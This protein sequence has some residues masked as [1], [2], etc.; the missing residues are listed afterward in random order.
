MSH[1]A[2]PLT[3][4]SSIGFGSSLKSLQA[5]VLRGYATFTVWQHHRKLLRDLESMPIAMRK[6]LGWPAIDTRQR[7]QNTRG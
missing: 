5:T 2:H 1:I 3:Q 7:P 4:T 6:D